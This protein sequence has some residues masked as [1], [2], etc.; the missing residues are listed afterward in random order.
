M[1]DPRTTAKN[2]PTINDSSLVPNTKYYYRV[3]TLE[4]GNVVSATSSVVSAYT[5]LAT[6]T[7]LKFLSQAANQLVLG[8]N[9]VSS[10]T[11]YLVERSL[12]DVTYSTI[13]SN[14]AVTGFTDNS[15]AAAT[16]N[17]IASRGSTRTRAALRRTTSQPPRQPRAR[18][19]PRP[20]Q[21]PLPP[22]API[23]SAEAAGPGPDILGRLNGT[24]AGSAAPRLGD[25]VAA[26]R[27]HGDD[28]QG[29][30]NQLQ[31]DHGQEGADWSFRFIGAQSPPP[32]TP[33]LVAVD[34]TLANDDSLGRHASRLSDSLLQAI[35][36]HRRKPEAREV[37][38][39]F[40]S[41]PTWVSV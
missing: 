26:G 3:V 6:V 18:Q 17:T 10:A 9:A 1:G 16:K 11:T 19:P 8:W 25:Y 39:S 37:D 30:D 31:D 5:R 7:G 14:L 21:Q 27:G 35:A 4:A 34:N 12:D 24:R 28:R 20:S 2:V 36:G 33:T 38:R 41:K 13:I 22:A 29:H 32:V 23:A 15:V 40:S